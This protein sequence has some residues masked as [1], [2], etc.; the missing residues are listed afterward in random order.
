MFLFAVRMLVGFRFSCWRANVWRQ[1]TWTGSKEPCNYPPH[2]CLT[3]EP[4]PGDFTNQVIGTIS[5]V[6]IASQPSKPYVTCA[7]S[8]P[9]TSST[10]ADS[11]DDDDPL[12]SSVPSSQTATEQTTSADIPNHRYLL[13]RG[14]STT[15]PTSISAAASSSDDSVSVVVA[16]TTVTTSF[17]PSAVSAA[18]SVSGAADP[19]AASKESSNESSNSRTLALPAGWVGVLG[20]AAAHFARY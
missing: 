13:N 10:T 6:T 11:D 14:L 18:P 15:N 12:S 1:G 16:S 4:L 3:R 2:C 17:L 19:F 5:G 7:A 8:A 20:I 9:P